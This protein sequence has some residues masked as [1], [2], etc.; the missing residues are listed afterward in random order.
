MR[1]EDEFSRFVGEVEPGLRRAL[2]A[3]YGTERGR[4]AVAEALGLG[5]GELASCAIDDEPRRLFVSSGPKP[6]A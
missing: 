5:V 6:D 1:D 4:D 3:T 2:V